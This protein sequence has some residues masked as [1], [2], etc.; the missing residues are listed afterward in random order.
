VAA[1]V[2]I[3]NRGATRKAMLHLAE[4][5]H[6]RVLYLAGP[7]GT[8]TTM[9][10]SAGARAAAK[11]GAVTEVIVRAGDLG[12]SSGEALVG[13]ALRDGLAFTAVLAS[14]D[15]MAIGALAALRRAGIAVPGQVSVIGVDDIPI[16][17]D[18]TP[19]LTTVHLP[20]VELGA[21]AGRL[22]VRTATAAADGDRPPATLPATLVERESVGPVPGA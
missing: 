19:A 21:A 18:V 20:L 13:Q 4:H 11:A 17:A 12:R 7:P 9:A 10:R 16:A 15:L 14:N 22:A 5:G 6:R 2:D 8:T 1:V 3:D